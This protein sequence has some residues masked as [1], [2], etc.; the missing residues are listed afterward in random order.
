MRFLGSSF[1]FFI[2]LVGLGCQRDL[3]TC[4]ITQRSC[5]ELVYYKT[6]ALRGDGYDPFAGLPPIRVITEAE[7]RNE[8]VV[9][10]SQFYSESERIWDEAYSLLHLYPPKN[11][12]VDGGIS[13]STTD[14]LRDIDPQIDDEATHVYAYFNPA[15][16]TI[17]LV[18]HPGET[19]VEAQRLAMM[20]LAHE[21]VHALQDREIDLQ[22]LFTT[23]DEYLAS[24]TFVEGEARFYELLFA[25]ELYS[26]KKTPS[27]IV[28]MTQEELRY[29]IQN[30]YLLGSP[31]YAA[32][33]LIYPLGSHYLATIW[34]TGGNAAIRRANKAAPTAT[35]GFLFS[36]DGIPPRGTPRPMTCNAPNATNFVTIG[37]DRLG[38][39]VLFTF[40]YGWQI[41]QDL[42]L[43]T[44]QGWRDDQ[45][46]VHKNEQ[47]QD[48]GVSWRI[49]LDQPLDP[50]IYQQLTR[51]GELLITH[52]GNAIEIT[53]QSTEGDVLWRPDPACR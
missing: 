42:A 29:Y 31:L 11:K 9:S 52:Q 7:F 22:D 35:L 14:D 20:S 32:E 50:A 26:L 51:T 30:F 27:Q 53:T 16:R 43:A 48:L 5:Q 21:F 37:K 10:S 2:V 38:A 46:L 23:S 24:K 17:T 15:E 8:L 1:I 33:M 41:P 6:L 4:D 45:M 36:P 34:E 18:S 19:G 40:L 28:R 44:A 47:T 49:E 3:H 39:V 25:N 13:D 12:T